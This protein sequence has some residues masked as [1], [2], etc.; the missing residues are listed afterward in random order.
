M[1]FL[2]LHRSFLFEMILRSIVDD[3]IRTFRVIKQHVDEQISH[4]VGQFEDQVDLI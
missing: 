1:N 3:E 4:N 2:M